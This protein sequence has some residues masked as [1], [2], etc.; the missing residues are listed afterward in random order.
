MITDLYSDGKLDII[1][2]SFVNNLE[3]VE[4]PN[5]GKPEGWPLEVGQKLYSTP[6]LYDVDMDLHF[7]FYTI[8]LLYV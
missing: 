3:V 1:V 5:G 2:P 6:L 8:I 7:Y 4:G